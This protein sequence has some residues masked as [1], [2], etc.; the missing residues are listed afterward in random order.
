MNKKVLSF[1]SLLIIALSG[2]GQQFP[3]GYSDE[4]KFVDKLELGRGILITY[5]LE[6]TFG[7]KGTPYLFEE[8]QDGEFFFRDRKKITDLKINY[9]CTTG[10]LLFSY[11]GKNYITT[12]DDIDYFVIFPSQVDTFILFN[13]Q[14]L[15]NEK[16]P[17]YL[18]IL[19]DQHFIL[20]KRHMKTFK[21][22]Q[23]KTPY[24]A[25]K[26]YN[27][28]IDKTEYFLKLS[29]N[30]IISLKPKMK[31]ILSVFPSKAN[32]IRDFI[33]NEKISLKKETDLIR[34]IKY[35]DSL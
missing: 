19:Y 33:K 12:R 7:L 25:E 31:S 21:E 16:H 23:V 15:P 22:A 2:F 4:P 29:N 26:D 9:N 11:D 34:A 6:P 17:E 5:N 1:F 24:H 35:C 14:L 30:E 28:Y 18:E 32:Q 20:F 27:E 3:Q 10:D 13:K 8:F